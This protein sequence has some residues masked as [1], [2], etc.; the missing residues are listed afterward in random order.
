MLISLSYTICSKS[1]SFMNKIM[2]IPVLNGLSNKGK[3]FSCNQEKI[4][5]YDAQFLVS[6]KH[7]FFLSYFNHC[8]SFLTFLSFTYNSL[9]W[10]VRDGEKS[11]NLGYDK[12][13]LSKHSG[14]D[15]LFNKGYWDNWLTIWKK[16]KWELYLT[17]YLK[18]ILVGSKIWT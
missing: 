15:V 11:T 10:E 18:W 14:K 6:Q 12:D 16:M 2:M 4:K 3:I 7:F 5:K 17:P 13:G 9:F 1:P 8:F